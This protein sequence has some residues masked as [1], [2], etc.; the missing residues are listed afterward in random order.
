MTFRG[1]VP[2]AC[3]LLAWSAAPALPQ[4][5][6]GPVEVEPNESRGTT[7]ASQGV[8]PLP[9]ASAIG[10]ITGTSTGFSTNPG[11]ASIDFY[12]VRTAAAPLAIY[13]H[14]LNIEIEGGGSNTGRLRGLENQSGSIDQ[15]I[16]SSFTSGGVERF[17]QWYSFG[18]PTEV[19]YTVHG[20]NSA[21]SPYRVDYSVAAVT[22]KAAGIL[23]AGDI[24][25]STVNLPG[26]FSDTEMFLYDA[27]LNQIGQND[28]NVV[29]GVGGHSRIDIT[30]AAGTYFVA[31]SDAGT[32]TNLA[33]GTAAPLTPFSDLSTSGNRVDFP[34]V[35][36]RNSVAARSAGQ[37]SIAISDTLG[38]TTTP[39][40]AAGT[41]DVQWYQFIVSP[42]PQTPSGDI[43]GDF[44]ANGR[45]IRPFVTAVITHSTALNDVCAADYDHDGAVDRDD[46]VPF[47]NR[48]L[49]T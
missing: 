20:T 8:W 30:L 42:C 11:P 23:A 12:H 29:P 10:V 44:V 32:V 21:T 46:V 14:R 39:S 5:G 28:D 7:D 16:Q 15:F 27:N 37:F 2:L 24:A 9:A 36:V 31:V 18:R 40:D 38:T 48:L 41:F 17:V 26:E 6:T 13:R 19:Y 22:P 34:D 25:L 4:F 45:D 35:L 1:T 43:N 3:M 47:I 33:N 49:G